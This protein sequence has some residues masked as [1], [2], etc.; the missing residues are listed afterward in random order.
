MNENFL[1]GYIDTHLHTSPDPRPRIVSD[2]EAGHQAREVGMEALVIK[3]HLES[4]AGRAQ[5]AS[6]LTN[7]K[8]IGGVTLN[9]S[10]GG[11]NAQA[12]E[13]SALHRGRM[14]W[15]PTINHQEV[16]LDGEK[17]EEVLH[18]V[19]DYDLVLGTGHLNPEEIFNVLD[20]AKS[21][22][23]DRLVVNHPLTRVV[24]AT[25]EEQK[26]M[27]RQAYLEHCY[28]ACMPLHDGLSPLKIAEAIQEVGPERC[29]MATD[30]GQTHNPTPLVGLQMYVKEMLK[31]GI[32][33]EDIER[34][35]RDNP[36]A[37]IF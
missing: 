17:L 9:L 25:L 24:G 26:K 11:L 28:V 31:Q 22:K 6:K 15:L 32:S 5:I 13:A 36:A 12:V 20:L 4:T 1:T 16:A 27:S 30:F 7:F 29:I 34:M 10:V 14:V 8:V 21:I 2:V 23:V 3:S 19:R 18:M 35:C 37:L 33:R